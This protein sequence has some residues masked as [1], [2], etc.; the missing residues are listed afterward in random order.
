MERNQH[1]TGTR[2]SR[3][4]ANAGVSRR[5]I[6]QAGAA[7]AAALALTGRKTIAGPTCATSPAQTEGPYWVDEMLNRADI[8][9]DPSTGIAQV[10]M[11]LR[12]AI[13]VS[14]ITGASSCAPLSGAYVDVWHCNASGAYSD[15]AAGAGN[16]NTLGQ[17]WLRGYQITDAHGNARFIT[18]YPGWYNGRT[19]HIHFRVRK[20][21]GTTVTFNFV[22]QLYFVDSISNAIYARTAPYN[23]R[24]NRNPA[25]NAQDNIY[26]ATMLMRM[27]DN[28]D[29]AVASYNV[30]VNS[31]P[32]LATILPVTPIDED[33]QDHLNDFGGGTPPL[34]AMA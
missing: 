17:R 24:L 7:S 27:A 18:V 32:G 6:I 33:S 29:H 25:T 13:N 14:E 16:P 4:V 10:G 19:V 28:G 31:T 9:S 1:E 12:L 22:S 2:A 8:R 20:F 34:R 11:P 23:A 5:G 21:S 15:V 3:T 26:S 30:V